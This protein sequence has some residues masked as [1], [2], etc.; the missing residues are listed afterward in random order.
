M[1]RPGLYRMLI[2]ATLILLLGVGALMIAK[3]VRQETW[4]EVVLAT[5]L[6]GGTYND[7]GEQFQ[8]I[9]TELPGNPIQVDILEGKTGSVENL[10]HLLS[11]K[12]DMAFV[13]APALSDVPLEKLTQIRA[14]W[15]VYK[16]A[17]Q[18]VVR[19]DSGIARIKD[20][21]F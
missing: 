12:A 5:G 10:E 6:P 9:L 7:L 1:A 2:V 14:L 16:D 20:H 15:S 21:W 17:V 13:A 19:K 3:L 11:A 4:D 18:V 8:W